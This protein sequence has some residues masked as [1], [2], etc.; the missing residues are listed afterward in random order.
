LRFERQRPL[1]LVY[2]GLALECGYR[3]DLVVGGIIVEVKAVERLLPIHEAQVLTY[4]RLTGLR[5]ALLVNFHSPALRRGLRRLTHNPNP[6]SRL[7]AFM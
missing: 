1:P 5:T 2:K 4:L 7:P 6:P 3:L